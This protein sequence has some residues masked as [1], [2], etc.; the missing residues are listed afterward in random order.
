M[1]AQKEPE[2][3]IEGAD[4]IK[5]HTE[6]EVGDID[7]QPM[8]QAPPKVSKSQLFEQYR[9]CSGTSSISSDSED[10]DDEPL[11]DKSVLV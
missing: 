7:D 2:L 5:E 11:G 8:S 1:I 3:V 4:A 6:S 10:S 9:S